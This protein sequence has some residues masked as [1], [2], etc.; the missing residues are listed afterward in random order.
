ME[1]ALLKCSCGA[2]FEP[3]DPFI[4]SSEVDCIVIGFTCPACEIAHFAEIAPS[5]VVEG[6]A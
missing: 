2:E 1:K 6:D 4:D 3:A 5:S